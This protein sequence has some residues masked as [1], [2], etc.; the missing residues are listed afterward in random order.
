MACPHNNWHVPQEEVDE[1]TILRRECKLKPGKEKAVCPSLGAA[2][3]GLQKEP[4]ATQ[5]SESEY[6]Y[7]H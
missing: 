1:I 2:L 6:T 3:K 4:L 5:E 7:K